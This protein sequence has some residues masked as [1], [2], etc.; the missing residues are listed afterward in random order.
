MII[1]NRIKIKQYLV[2]K[3]N[4][5]IYILV[6][7]YPNKNGISKKA[8]KMKNK[9]TIIRIKRYRQKGICLY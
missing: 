9:M 7:L 4:N 6:L 2:K 3:D 5:Q 1:N 8:A